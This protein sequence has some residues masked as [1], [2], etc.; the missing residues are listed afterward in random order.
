MPIPNAQDVLI[1]LSDDSINMMFAS[2]T[3]AGKLKTGDAQGCFDTGATVGS[4]LPPGPTGCDTLTIYTDATNTT[5]ND[6]A[7]V[8][9]RGYCYGIKEANC[10]ALTYNNP[11]LNAT[12]NFN[13]TSTESGVCHGVSGHVCTDAA[14]TG[15]DLIKWG[16]CAITPNFNLHASQALLFCAKG[17]VPP[18]MLFPNNAVLSD[19]VPTKLRLN[20]LTVALVIDRAAPGTLGNH[21][22]D[23]LLKNAPGCFAPGTSTAVDCNLLSTCLDL[24]LNFNMQN[25]VCPDGKPGFKS[26]FDSIQVVSREI[27]VVCSGVTSPTSD[28]K[29]L[30]A[31]SDENTIT[32][33]I[34]TNAGAFSPEI[35]GAGLDLGGFITC[36][37]AKILALETDASPEL[38]DYLAITCKIP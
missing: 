29:A 16:A 15:G 33:P 22:V 23:G 28:Q 5:I 18:R 13:L 36:N 3:A 32:I 31:A 1:G 21:A 34:G 8:A 38:R 10:N 6:A 30:Q 27:G 24:D 26:I 25:S 2:L 7:T 19:S 37:N 35:C 9:A 12:D 4:L 17:D 20:D 11:L 14:V